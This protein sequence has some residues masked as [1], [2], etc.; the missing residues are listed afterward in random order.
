MLPDGPIDKTFDYLVPARQAALAVVGA[1][2]RVP[3]HGRRVSGW[4]VAVDVSPPA[5]VAL[6][7]VLA[8]RGIGPPAQVVELAMWAAHRWAGRAASIL[9]AA[10]P[11]TLVARLP[12]PLMGTV[13]I[14]GEAADL[15]TE[16]LSTSGAVVRR[17]PSVDP[18]PLVLAAARVGPALVVTPSVATARGLAARVRRAGVGVAVLPRDWA[19]AQAGASVTIGARNA[20]W[21]PVPDLAVVVVID[22]HDEAL[23]EERVPAWHARDVAIERAQRAGVP[24]V[25]VSPCPSLEAL[26]W[27]PLVTPSRAA[28][29]QGWPALEVVDMRRADDPV[30]TGLYS[31]ALVRVLRSGE[32]VVCVLNRTGRARL[33]ACVACGELATCERCGAAVIQPSADFECPR[34]ATA[35]PP[36]CLRC[37]STKFKNLRAGVSRVREEL[38]AL[39]G[40]PVVDVTADEGASATARVHVGTEAALHRVTEADAVAFLDF[41]QELLAPRYRAAEE[42]FALLA[43]AARLV[44]GRRPGS[45]VLVQTRVPNHEVLDAALHADPARVSDAEGRRRRDLGFPPV[46]AMAAISGPGADEFVATLGTP[47]GIDVL[48]PAKGTWL[49]RAASPDELADALARVTRPAARLRIE[50][51]PLRV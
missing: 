30:R 36:I 8:V 4:I 27:G 21:A 50:V 28:E 41:D 9:T 34:C 37:H 2:V 14:G 7:E 17:P 42:A 44:G 33:L 49:V 29:R 39:A 5:G 6:A 25:L 24:A 15:P 47:L 26:K 12:P 11:P 32:R 1:Q 13:P 43:R 18:L 45:R 23:K 48:G 31:D 16:A 19:Q 22:E 46:K 35:R 20:V 38:E 3:L 40:E 51:D 10:S